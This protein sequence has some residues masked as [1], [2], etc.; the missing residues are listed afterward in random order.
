MTCTFVRSLT[1][2]DPIPTAIE[3]IDQRG[4]PAR[5]LVRVRDDGRIDLISSTPPDEPIVLTPEGTAN[6]RNQ[7]GDVLAVALREA[8]AA[9]R[10]EAP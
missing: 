1:M 3:G 8:H 5:V 2:R 7:L 6:L 10:Y 4:K 9:R